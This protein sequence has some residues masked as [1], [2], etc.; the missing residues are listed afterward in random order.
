[1][2]EE[3]KTGAVDNSTRSYTEGMDS[4]QAALTLLHSPGLGGR[5]TQ[6][7]FAAFGDAATA[8]QASDSAL[9][10]AGLKSDQV[11]ALRAVSEESIRPDLE[12]ADLDNNH[13]IPLDSRHYPSNLREIP[14]PP[15]LLYI[16]GD[17]DVLSAPQVAMVG[18]RNPSAGGRDNAK[19]FAAEL[20]TRGL[21]ITS[22]MASG[23]DAAAHHGALSVDGLSIA[24]TG[25]GLDRVY[26]ASNRELAHQLA[27]QGA[28][29]SE[30]PIGTPPRPHHFPRRNR[31]ISALS[32]GVLVVEATV[33]SGSLITARL[34]AEQGREVLAIPGSIHNPM[35]RGCH[36]LIRQGAKLVETAEDVLEEL[37]SQID[38]SGLLAK[39]SQPSS[40]TTV[41]H[42]STPEAPAGPEADA[43]Y[44]HLIECIGHDPVSVDTLIERSGFSSAA[45]SSMLLML[46]LT[47]KVHKVSGG[48]YSIK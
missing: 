33:R 45:L 17:T 42:P 22:G 3:T 44:A 2:G 27:A 8:L 16:T 24:V 34:A 26:P 1:M 15:P 37:A 14:D 29:I 13:L 30:L 43:D 40:G 41:E 20:A 18:S 32:C 47:A 5:A 48:R 21:C 11:S 6:K 46:E 7:L 4:I 19:H 39:S 9:Q 12:W 28:L 23:I 38:T 10:A 36:A 25:T 31:I 35:A